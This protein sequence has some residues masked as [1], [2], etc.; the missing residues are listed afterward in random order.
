MP[1]FTI[2]KHTIG[3]EFHFDFMLEV[4]NY[5]KLK[6][7]RI[8]STDFSKPQKAEQNFDHRKIYLDYEG[9]V[10]SKGGFVK[11]FDTG[12]YEKVSWTKK[13]IV[14]KIC[15]ENLKGVYKLTLTSQQPGE[16]SIWQLTKE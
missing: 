2:S 1:R 11:I 16:N 12:T 7:F 13:G 6:A 9:T 8:V 15:S 4:E 10:K 3:D 5:D 14:L